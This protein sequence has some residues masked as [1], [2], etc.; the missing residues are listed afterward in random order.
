MQWKPVLLLTN[1]AI[2]VED[3]KQLTKDC[4][5]SSTVIIGT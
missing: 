1:S 4:T 2:S 3:L 5:L